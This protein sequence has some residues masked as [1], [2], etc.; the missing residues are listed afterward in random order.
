MVAGNRTALQRR[1]VAELEGKR[2]KTLPWERKGLSRVERVIA[3]LEFLPIT[4]GILIGKKLQLLPNQRRFIERIYGN[5]DV[6]IA[7]R[8]EP[9]GNGKTGLVSGLALCHLLGPEAE[10]RGECYSAAVNRLQSSLMHGEMAAIVEQVPEFA[11]RCRIRRGGQRRCIEV[12]SGAGNGSVYEALSA[13]ARRGHGLAPSWWAYDELAQTRDRKLL[14]ALTT[15]M[16]K[17]KRALGIVLSTQAED[18]EHPLSQLIDDGLAGTDSSI[19]VD[20]TAAP[21]DAD[22]FDEAVIRACNPALGIFLDADTLLKEARQA[23]RLPSS[24]SAFRNLRCNQRI[25]AAP[26]LLVTPSVWAQGNAPIDKEMF[27][28]GRPVYAGLDLSARLDLTAMVLAAQ[29]DAG[30]VHLWP[31]AWTPER[32][33]TMR[34]Q[35]DAA[36]YAAW[37]NSGALLA[38]PGLAIDYDYVIGDIAVVTEGMN[39]V[40]VAYDQWNINALKQACERTGVTLPLEPFIQGYKS[41][42]PAISAFEVECTEGRIRHGAHPVLRWCIANTMLVR[43]P[44]G[45]PQQNRKPEKRR[46]NGRIDLAVAALMAMGALKVTVAPPE[47]DIAALIG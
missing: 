35:R 42:T 37:I 30:V 22:V 45:T 16:G 5:T 31:L 20:L 25:S 24:E 47:Y 39:L 33:V 10:E 9:R 12:T 14:D 15:G 43:G 44:A 18:D 1:A 46:G 7:V 27:R 32:T 2:K 13:D 26:D 6:R 41:Y 23:R 3:F 29:D 40:A 17:R 36:P 4:K 8:S 34:E 38:T 21:D 11:A 28:D 19:V